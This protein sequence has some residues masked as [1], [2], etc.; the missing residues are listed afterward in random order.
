VFL[1][2]GPNIVV[3]KALRAVLLNPQARLHFFF[4]FS[5]R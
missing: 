1:E 3:I 2:E 5:C 4:L